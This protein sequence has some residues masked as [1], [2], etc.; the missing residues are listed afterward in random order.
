MAKG[1][2]LNRTAAVDK[3]LN[4]CSVEAHLLF[5][6]TIP[7]LDRDGL[8]AGEPMQHL[9]TALPFRPDF[10][11][12]YDDLIQELIDADL[13]VRYNTNRGR[14]LFFNGFKDNQTIT[15][16]REGASVFDPPP[17]YV[18][19]DTGLVLECQDT[20]SGIDHEELMSKSGVA[21]DKNTLKSSQV[22]STSNGKSSDDELVDPEIAQAITRWQVVFAGTPFA[23]KPPVEKFYR[24]L[25]FGGPD[26]L[27]HMIEQ[28]KDKD[29][30]TGWLYTT[31][32]N[33]RKDGEVAPYIAQQVAGKQSANAP[34]V[35]VKIGIIW[36]DG[37]TGEVETMKRV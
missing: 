16:S 25:A 10:F 1:R 22:K 26:V 33:W 13:V 34:A 18:R 4:E 37:T 17:G 15:Y 21:H 23:V 11:P 27:Y 14:V 28:A 7:H 6:M 3:E 12:R 5:L 19:T 24:W 30:P 35:P 8:I 20:N 32:D 36:P 29:N 2:M 31:Y 9:G